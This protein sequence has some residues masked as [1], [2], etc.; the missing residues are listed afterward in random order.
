MSLGT[1]WKSIEIRNTGGPR[2]IREIGTPKICW[3][4]MN[5]HIKIPT[6]TV[7]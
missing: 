2:Y 6:I 7:N 3:H 4:I 5:W 1:P